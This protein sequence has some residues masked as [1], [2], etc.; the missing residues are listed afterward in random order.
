[1]RGQILRPLGP[2]GGNDDPLFR[3]K[4]LTK[5]GHVNPSSFFYR[6]LGGSLQSRLRRRHHALRKLSSFRYLRTLLRT[7]KTTLVIPSPERT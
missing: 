6:Q 2:L 5:L 4:V 3:K 1:M 7:L